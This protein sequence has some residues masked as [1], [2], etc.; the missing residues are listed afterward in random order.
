MKV[1][2][3]IDSFS[4]GGAE[5]LLATLARSG[6]AAGLELQV[7]SLAPY[8]AENTGMLTVLRST[9]I[10]LSTIAVPRLAHLRAIPKIAMAIRRSGC[11][12][13]HAHLGYSATLAPPAA[14]ITGRPT[15]CSFH[16]M[17][18][19]LHGREVVKDWLAVSVA[20]RSAGLI[21]VSAASMRAFANRYPVNPRT[22]SVVPNGIDVEEFSPAPATFPAELGVPEGAPVATLV[23]VMRPPK[24]HVV[25][26]AAWP[27][28]L[29]RVP[30]AHLLFV[31]GGPE[32]EAL[33]QQARLLGVA[34]RVVFAGFRS[35]V[36]RLLRASALAVLP[37]ET[38]ALPTSLIEAHAC[39][40]AVVA[41]DVGGVPEVVADGES[42]L[43]VPSGDPGRFAE[44]VVELLL[45][46]DRRASMGVAGRR[47]ATTRFDM[48]D[49]ARRLRAMY[50][51][52]LAGQPVVAHAAADAGLV[53]G[54]G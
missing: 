54:T 17:P 36:P 37:T 46:P 50:Q 9:G 31:G 22:W 30:E 23:G 6:P 28:V 47:I 32:E 19:T 10:P 26:I 3:V 18:E 4:F 20:S 49:W 48:N 2:I 34:D 13:V 27:S 42:G 41:T 5:R 52:A 45:D 51:A 24:G 38:E 40:K 33:R 21:F 43:L 35:D 7:A 39:G 8:T 53:R 15:L 16:T 12:I 29:R 44:A 11:D 25:A 14:M 1:F